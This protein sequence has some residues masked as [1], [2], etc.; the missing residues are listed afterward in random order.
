MEDICLR[1]TVKILWVRSVF[2]SFFSLS[3]FRSKLAFKVHTK[4]VCVGSR[5]LMLVTSFW[6]VIPTNLKTS[7]ALTRQAGY[8]LTSKI[9]GVL[10]KNKVIKTCDKQDIRQTKVVP[11]LGELSKDDWIL[12]ELRLDLINQH[13]FIIVLICICIYVAFPWTMITFWCVR[14]FCTHCTIE[15]DC[16]KRMLFPVPHFVYLSVISSF[17]STVCQ[18]TTKITF[19]IK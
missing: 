6:G 19:V 17:R 4:T 16:F 2:F 1:A 18:I 15:C 10:L 14:F 7:P 5:F 8:V 9:W 12:F 13:N 3:D 11:C